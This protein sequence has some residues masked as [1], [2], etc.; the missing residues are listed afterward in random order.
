MIPSSDR[1]RTTYSQQQWSWAGNHNSS[2]SS[3]CPEWR[4]KRLGHAL[5]I[6]WKSNET[7]VSP[8]SYDSVIIY[9]F[10]CLSKPMTFFP[11]WKTKRNVYSRMY[12][13]LFSIECKWM[14]TDFFSHIAINYLLEAFI[15]FFFF[16]GVWHPGSHQHSLQGRE[17]Y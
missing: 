8:K 6:K 14:M 13:L 7:I 15:V 11:Q 4:R 9:S 10:S 17:Q 12:K 3:W 16:F 2:H 1:K 5:A